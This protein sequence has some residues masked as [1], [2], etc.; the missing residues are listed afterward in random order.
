[1]PLRPLADGQFFESLKNFIFRINEHAALKGYAVIVGRSK[2]SKL[3]VKRKIWLICDREKKMRPQRDKGQ[4]HI[5]NRCIDCP[6]F[7]IAQRMEHS[8]G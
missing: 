2:K 6:F 4:K 3:D 7:F 8:D 1:M 5:T